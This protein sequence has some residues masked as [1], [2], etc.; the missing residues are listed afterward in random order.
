C[1]R[2]PFHGDSRAEPL[3]ERLNEAGRLVESLAPEGFSQCVQWE[4]VQYVLRLEPC[5]S[6]LI[7][8]CV[9]EIEFSS[10]VCVGIHSDLYS[11]I[12]HSTSVL[13]G[14][15]Q[16]IRAR[17]YF[18]HAA[19]ALRMLDQPWKIDFIAFAFEQQPAG[20]MPQYVEVRVVH[21]AHDAS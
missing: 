18:K 8:P 15:V 11:C 21:R 3:L 10:A 9:Y 7:E 20:C 5:P 1:G 19:D 13:G 4:R 12:S 16:T 17:V 2:G 14:K 6:R